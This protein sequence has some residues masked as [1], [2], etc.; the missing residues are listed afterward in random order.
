MPYGDAGMRVG[1]DRG[2]VLN[3]EESWTESLPVI[4]PDAVSR[5]ATFGRS[6]YRC[7]GHPCGLVL[8]CRGGFRAVP[9]CSRQS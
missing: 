1:D 8:R 3:G 9:D 6:R 4:P 2:E 7:A 5:T